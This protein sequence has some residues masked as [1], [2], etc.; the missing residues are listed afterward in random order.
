MKMRDEI[1]AAVIFLSRLL[2]NDNIPA[3]KLDDFATKLSMAM[4]DKFQDHWYSECPTKGQGYRCIRIGKNEP[5]DPVLGR[6]VGECG[7]IY[8]ELNLPIDMT[9]WVDPEEVCCRFGEN[10]GVYHQVASFK[11]GCCDNKAKTLDIENLIAQQRLEVD[12]Q[13]NF[14]TTRI[15]N[16]HLPHTGNGYD[17]H[18]KSSRNGYKKHRHHH[19]HNNNQGYHKSTPSKKPPQSCGQSFLSYP[20]PNDQFHWS[21]PADEVKA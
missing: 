3:D 6:V 10:R 2:R 17:W 9:L 16:L 8:D 11:N 20:P 12:R 15:N 14:T 21:K 7:L 19:H 13:Q 4:N 1:S 5:V 18:Q